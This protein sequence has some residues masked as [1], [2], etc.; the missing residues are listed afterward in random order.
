M[1]MMML[2]LLLRKMLLVKQLFFEFSLDTIE[3]GIGR[4]IGTDDLRLWI[5]RRWTLRRRMFRRRIDFWSTDIFVVVANVGL[6]LLGNVEVVA[7]DFAA[8]V[9]VP[10]DFLEF[11]KVI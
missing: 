2:L 3:Y 9:H 5:F 4:A 10:F 7:P 1:M 8:I 11:G 6:T